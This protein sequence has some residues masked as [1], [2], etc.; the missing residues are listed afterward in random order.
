MKTSKNDWG[1]EPVVRTLFSCPAS[2]TE[3]VRPGTVAV[4][5]APSDWTHSSRIGARF[6]PRALRSETSAIGRSLQEA[7]ALRGW[8]DL[9]NGCRWTLRDEP[10]LVD[11]GDAQIFP[12]DVERMTRS[13]A[14][15]TRAIRAAGG[16]PLVLGG[17]HY[18]SYPACLGY[19][20]G[21]ALRDP[22]ARF[23]YIQID[24]HLDFT[25]SL[26]AW[27]DKNHAT[28]ARR[29]SE[30]PNIDRSHM[31]WIGTSGWVD[32]RELALIEDFGGKVLSNSDIHAMGA[33]AAMQVALQY[34]TRS[35]DYLYLTID[36]DA[37]DA[38]YLPGTG[39][40]VQSGITPRQYQQML[41]VLSMV[42]IDGMDIAE[43]APT[44][45]P[46]GRSERIVAHLLFTLL[47][48]H[49]MK[50]MESSAGVVIE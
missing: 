47:R 30:L 1:L 36:I 13:I 32:S 21:L 6:G 19:S 10:A 45:D 26:G 41:Q 22:K 5:G 8:L 27:G 37:M 25:D 46:S 3:D 38:A 44:L 18:N 12:E 7:G 2:S 11:C 4:W 14:D 17:D 15:G 50:P 34:A 29:I 28:N 24:G 39:S 35:V 31:V 42:R 49:L 9:T 40:I 48:K 23:G 20:E 43:T 33:T 16:I